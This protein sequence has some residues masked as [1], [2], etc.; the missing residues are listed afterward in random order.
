MATATMGV[1]TAYILS[2]FEDSRQGQLNMDIK[3]VH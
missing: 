1:L 2:F 3:H